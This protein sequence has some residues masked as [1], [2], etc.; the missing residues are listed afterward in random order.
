MKT[1]ARLRTTM[2]LLL[3]TLLVLWLIYSVGHKSRLTLVTWLLV[4]TASGA[5]AYK[6]M[7]LAGLHDLHTH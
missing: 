4:N 1:V 6:E 5:H 2:T 3:S 7:A